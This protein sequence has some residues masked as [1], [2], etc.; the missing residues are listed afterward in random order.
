[1]GYGATALRHDETEVSGAGAGRS[2]KRISLDVSSSG[3]VVRCA[4]CDFW[5]AFRFTRREGWEAAREHER[6]AHPGARQATTALH[7]YRNTPR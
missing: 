7:Y 5:T 3:V 6:R 4:D 2:V 1:M